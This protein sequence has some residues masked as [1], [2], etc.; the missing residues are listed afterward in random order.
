ML[1]SQVANFFKKV[2][3][4]ISPVVAILYLNCSW[5]MEFTF[6]Y[7][8]NNNNFYNRSLKESFYTDLTS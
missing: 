3:P 8:H 7:S 6:P 2:I 1:A 4:L 5:K